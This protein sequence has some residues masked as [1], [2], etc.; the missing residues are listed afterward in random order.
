[1]TRIELLRAAVATERD[2]MEHEACGY[3]ATA[4]RLRRKAEWLAERAVRWI[5]EDAED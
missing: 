1:M 5:A 4:E 3:Y 2:A